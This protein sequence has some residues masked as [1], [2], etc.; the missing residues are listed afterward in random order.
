MSLFHLPFWKIFFFLKKLFIFNWRIITLQCCVGFCHITTWLIY[1]YMYMYT[2]TYVWVIQ[3]GESGPLPCE[4]PSYLPPLPTTEHWVEIPVSYSKFPLALY[5]TY[6]SVYVS[7]LLLQFIP[8]FPSPT[9]STSL[10]SMSASLLLP[11]K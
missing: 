8:P 7:M 2:Y 1:R 9:V 5:F 3:I 11:C 6:V 10:F 4:P